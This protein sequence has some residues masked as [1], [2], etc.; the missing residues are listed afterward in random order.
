MG[1]QQRLEDYWEKRRSDREESSKIPTISLVMLAK[2]A[3]STIE[4][5]LESV[6]G[7]MDYA[8]FQFDDEASS[9]KMRT[10]VLDVV[11]V[12]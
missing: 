4:R 5:A 3:E 6:A 8:V 2:N 11:E 9:E 1:A 12:P 7:F 10:I